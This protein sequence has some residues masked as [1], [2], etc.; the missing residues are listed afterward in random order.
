MRAVTK[1]FTTSA[2]LEDSPFDAQ[3]TWRAVE[4]QYRAQDDR[5]SRHSAHLLRPA[6]AWA[7]QWLD[8]NSNSPCVAVWY[9]QIYIGKGSLPDLYEAQIAVSDAVTRGWGV[10]SK[11]I[12]AT[13]VDE[14]L[15]IFRKSLASAPADAIA[16]AI[17]DSLTARLFGISAHP[18]NLGC[19]MSHPAPTV[20]DLKR[21]AS[22]IRDASSAL[23]AVL[24]KW[25]GTDALRYLERRVD[26]A[27]GT[28]AFSARTVHV[29]NRLSRGIERFIENL[30]SPT[31]RPGR[32]I[33]GGRENVVARNLAAIWTRCGLGDPKFSAQ[34]R[35]IRAC[36][37][38]LP[39]HDVHK[40]DVAQFMRSEL[41]KKRVGRGYVLIG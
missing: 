16:C 8:E 14:A 21:A 41:S 19:R 24:M 36:A 5:F 28:S 26:T 11:K 3:D 27:E 4:Q 10:V 23:E 2:E 29:V 1:F 18:E 32:P 22:E 7:G 39:W 40:A 37:V 15:R 38:A 20:T 12:P 13:S 6:G 17:G 35:F 9:R 31:R 25:E 33:K 30:E 34:A